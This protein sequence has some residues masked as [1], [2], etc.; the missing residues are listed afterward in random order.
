MN[1]KTVLME[2][3]C[4]SVAVKLPAQT[5][6]LAMRAPSP[7]TEPAAVIEEAL[8]NSIASPGLPQIAKDK[9]KA[10]PQ[11]RAVVV[12]S[13]NTRPVP[14]RGDAGILWPIIK[15]LF[16]QGFTSEQILVLVAT[17][18]H[19]PVSQEEL[20]SILDPRVLAA[21]IRIKNH[22]CRDQRGL[23]Y[24]GET[25]RGSKVY[26]NRHYM[27][28]DLKILTGLVEGHFMAGVSG[29]R[30]SVCPGLIGEESTYIFHGAPMLSSPFVQTLVLEGNPCHEESLEVAEMAGV[31]YIVNVT[32]DHQYNLTGIFAGDLREAHQE[33]VKK[34]KSYVTIPIAGEYDLVVT[35]AGFVGI[36]HYQAA[37]A[38]VESIPALKKGGRLVLVA[39][40]TDQDPVGGP[41]YRTVLH[42]LR[43]MGPERFNRLLLSPDWVFIPDQ[44]QVQMWAKI[45]NKI[46]MENLIY[47]SP[48]LSKKDYQIIPG[49]D[50]NKYLPKEIR[51]QADLPAIATV[52]ENA[53]GSYLSG[54][55]QEEQR[56][57][58]IAFLADGPYGVPLLS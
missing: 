16:D 42:L 48:Q 52:I 21:G 30:K 44:W 4:E 12:I 57:A 7:L 31:D 15:V 45:F 2:L 17:G 33:A 13:D 11:A 38:G 49:T 9:L 36:N 3:G 35:H 41:M 40:N 53:V 51:Y 24:L 56:K 50:G 26:I 14:Y 18:T 19:R 25:K 5:E 28:A 32:L 6:V 20:E 54:L 39:N 58:R 1:T 47:Y 8:V 27:E 37:K 46:P 29:G 55:S 34:L 43:L 22:D 10:S 23:V